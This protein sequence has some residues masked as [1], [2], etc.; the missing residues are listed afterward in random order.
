MFERVAWAGSCK[1]AGGRPCGGERAGGSRGR[2]ARERAR[3]RGSERAQTADGTL[4]VVSIGS[5]K[6]EAFAVDTGEHLG[7]RVDADGGL[8]TPTHRIVRAQP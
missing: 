3:R 8:Q 4:L 5:R 1:R 2:W 7:A 6:V